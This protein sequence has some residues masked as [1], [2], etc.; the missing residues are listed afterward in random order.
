MSERPANPLWPL[1]G[2]CTRWCESFTVHEDGDD[3]VF[4]AGCHGEVDTC[5]ISRRELP[6][7][8]VQLAPDRAF[9][10]IAFK[11]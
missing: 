6:S 1:C 5:R 7:G 4:T 9:P 8:E 3:I 11:A 10:S 2:R